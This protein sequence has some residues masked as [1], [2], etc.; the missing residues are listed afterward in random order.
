VTTIARTHEIRSRNGSD[1]E[2]RPERWPEPLAVPSSLSVGL[3]LTGGSELLAGVVASRAHGAARQGWEPTTARLAIAAPLLLAARRSSWR[4]PALGG[5]LGMALMQL[6]AA[7]APPDGPAVRAK[8]LPLV[9]LFL[10]GTLLRETVRAE[11]W[12]RV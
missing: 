10:L 5:A 4:V 2:P 7:P 3:A 6:V 12:E 11:R 8:A 1:P 9:R